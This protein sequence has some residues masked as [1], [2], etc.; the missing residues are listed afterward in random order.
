MNAPPPT[1][2]TFAQPAQQAGGMGGGMAHGTPGGMPAAGGIPM[3]GGTPMGMPGG[4]GTPGGGNMFARQARTG[5]RSRYVDTLNPNANDSAP[6]SSLLSLNALL[7]LVLLAFCFGVHVRVDDAC[8]CMC[9]H[10]DYQLNE[11][12]STDS[13][14]YR[15]F[16]MFR[17]AEVCSRWV[18]T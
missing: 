18:A 8:A 14:M 9:M 4:M 1:M 3:G 7:L 16:G 12:T 13:H 10:V 15:S 6:V 11:P 2:A 5:A 17:R